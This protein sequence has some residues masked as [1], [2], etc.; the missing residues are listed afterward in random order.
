LAL[1]SVLATGETWYNKLGF[2]SVY[3]EEEKKHNLEVIQQPFAAFIARI[4]ERVEYTEQRT[5]NMPT[6]ED[7]IHGM[8]YYIDESNSDITV[9]NLFKKVMADLRNKSL[10]CDNIDKPE[11]DWLVDIG[12]FL[13]DGGAFQYDIEDKLDDNIVLVVTEDDDNY[14]MQVKNI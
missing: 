1:L 10:I 7:L 13:T 9:Q 4:A 3:Y 12:F 5:R 2:K 14:V 11:M 8:Y 6:L